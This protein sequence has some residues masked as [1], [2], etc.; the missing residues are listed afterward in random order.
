MVPSYKMAFAGVYRHRVGN[1]P[2]KME[3]FKIGPFA[4]RN[5]LAGESLVIVDMRHPQ[6]V[7]D[8]PD[9]QTS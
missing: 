1:I 6:E 9:A 5:V 4:T 8:I 3:S 2:K 7:S